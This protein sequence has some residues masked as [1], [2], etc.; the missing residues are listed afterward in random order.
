M[1]SF[2]SMG[3]GSVA[4]L[5]VYAGYLLA[6][7]GN[8]WI[9]GL[10]LALTCLSASLTTSSLCRLIINYRRARPFIGPSTARAENKQGN[11]VGV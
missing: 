6:V 4:P 10:F 5:A 9:A 7:S 8:I 1:L 3:I 11:P 2:N